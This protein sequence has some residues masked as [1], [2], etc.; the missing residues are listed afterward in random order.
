MPVLQAA[1]QQTV[2][3][4]VM[5]KWPLSAPTIRF[6]EERVDRL[7]AQ[8]TA[9]TLKLNATAWEKGTDVLHLP[10][11]KGG[12]GTA[13]GADAMAKETAVFLHSA[14]I[15][16]APDLRD[17]LITAAAQGWSQTAD[18]MHHWTSRMGISFKGNEPTTL[19]EMRQLHDPDS[20][21]TIMKD[22]FT[23]V[24]PIKH[25][26]HRTLRPDE[27]QRGVVQSKGAPH[28]ACTVNEAVRTGSTT[29][30]SP[31]TH[32]SKFLTALLDAA[33]HEQSA[34]RPTHMVAIDTRITGV[35]HDLATMEGWAQ[36]GIPV[37]SQADHWAAGW[38]EALM[39]GHPQKI[40]ADSAVAG[41]LGLRKSRGMPR[42]PRPRERRED[43][44]LSMHAD[45]MRI[46]ARTAEEW[47][48][49][50]RSEP[51]HTLGDDQQPMKLHLCA[52]FSAGP[53][54]RDGLAT[55][56]R[57]E[58]AKTATPPPKGQAPPQLANEFW[59]WMHWDMQRPDAPEGF[60]L[61]PG[62]RSCHAKATHWAQN[63]EVQRATLCTAR[64]PDRMD[65]GRK[66]A[67]PHLRRTT[68]TTMHVRTAETAANHQNGGSVRHEQGIRGPARMA[69][70]PQRKRNSHDATN[71]ENPT[72]ADQLHKSSHEGIGNSRPEPPASPSRSGR[73]AVAT[74][75]E[76]ATS[77]RSKRQR[78]SV[79]TP[80][81]G[82][83]TDAMLS[84]PLHSHV[85]GSERRQQR[86]TRNS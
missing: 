13:S 44:L 68:T 35:S 62:W 11:C 70:P 67:N 45:T 73:H 64:C 8:R 85:T 55:K 17:A 50:T 19:E 7:I 49:K 34:Q 78:H 69:S 53:E 5:A 76:T 33:S 9:R 41:M 12:F 66:R 6:A 29:H 47:R 83:R 77:G 57:K 56:R 80:D 75:A 15:N 3:G 82:V 31:W 39:P 81:A 16:D 40:H 84:T 54:R 37:G 21:D 48:H 59:L 1:T 24:M 36:A 10:K 28:S 65:R 58:R 30:K 86:L 43:V 4:Y 79:A 74:F 46:V 20:D 14:L 32:A 71:A 51:A 61:T 27:V 26:V 60:V 23:M 42:H 2:M 63:Q 38:H 72:I 22:V 25:L 52:D 18:T